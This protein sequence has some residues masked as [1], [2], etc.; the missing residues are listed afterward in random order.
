MPHKCIWNCDLYIY[1]QSEQ[2]KESTE[3]LTASAAAATKCD[4]GFQTHQ[5]LTIELSITTIELDYNRQLLSKA[6]ERGKT[7]SEQQ[8]VVVH[9]ITNDGVLLNITKQQI[10]EIEEKELP[11]GQ[12]DVC[13][14]EDATVHEASD[15]VSFSSEGEDSCRDGLLRQKRKVCDCSVS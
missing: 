1:T 13:Y 2:W 6:A 8:E 3:Q 12:R 4:L 9:S 15:I 14:W 11:Q 10:A 7:I 5:Q